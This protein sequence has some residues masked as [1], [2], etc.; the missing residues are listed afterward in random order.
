VLFLAFLLALKPLPNVACL[1]ALLQLQLCACSPGHVVG[2]ICAHPTS[3][4]PVSKDTP[5]FMCMT[6]HAHLASNNEVIHKQSNLTCD[7]LSAERRS[8]QSVCHILMYM[9][10]PPRVRGPSGSGVVDQTRGGRAGASAG[11][12]GLARGRA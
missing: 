11:E 7:T 3:G 8:T 1:R 2:K 5:R 12:R 9:S 4:L 6:W 10:S